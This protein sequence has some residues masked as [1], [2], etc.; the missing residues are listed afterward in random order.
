MRMDIAVVG[1][2]AGLVEGIAVSLSRLNVAG[3]EDLR[4]RVH[5]VVDVTGVRPLHRLPHPDPDDRRLE[6]ELDN[7]GIDHGA[8]PAVV[9]RAATAPDLNPTPP[10]PASAPTSVLRS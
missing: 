4:I 1:E 8:L 2:D 6:G 3:F 10:R 5:G 9:T 7:G